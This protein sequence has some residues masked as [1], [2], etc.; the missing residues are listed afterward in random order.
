MVFMEPC[1]DSSTL[2]KLLSSPG[3]CQAG[4]AAATLEPH[5]YQME[6]CDGQY[7]ELPGGPGKSSAHRVEMMRACSWII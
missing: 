4:G 7:E 2:D 1:H 6:L 3:A 5:K